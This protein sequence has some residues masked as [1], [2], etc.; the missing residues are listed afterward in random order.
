MAHKMGLSLPQAPRH[1]HPIQPLWTKPRTPA[2]P[3]HSAVD[4][5]PSSRLR[6]WCGCPL[7]AQNT[8]PTGGPIEAPIE[9]ARKDQSAQGSSWAYFF[10]PFSSGIQGDKGAIDGW[11]CP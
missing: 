6:K 9:P 11:E 3:W 2:R 4:H 1:Q 8:D 10:R 7:H 5:H